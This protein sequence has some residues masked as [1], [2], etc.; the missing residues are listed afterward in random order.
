MNAP[1]ILP[2]LR[3]LYSRHPRHALPQSLGAA[4]SPVRARLRWRARP[5]VGD[6]GRGG[7]GLPGLAGVEEG[8]KCR[9]LL[10]HF[11]GLLIG[12][13]ILILVSTFVT[14]YW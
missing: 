5:R 1:A 6:R 9:L 7:C 3:D 12:L 4:V 13:A 10:Q 8:R 11:I 2:L 14:G